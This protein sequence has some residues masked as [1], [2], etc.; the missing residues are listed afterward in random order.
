M[1]LLQAIF[2]VLLFAWITLITS[3]LTG[4]PGS[5]ASAEEK[6]EI[7][8]QMGHSDNVTSVSFSPDGRYMLSGSSDDTMKLWE[9]SSGREIRTFQGDSSSV[10][11][12]AFS[13][14]RQ[15]RAFGKRGYREALGSVERQ[16]NKNIQGAYRYGSLRGLQPG[17]QICAIRKR[18]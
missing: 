11:S 8:V 16:G 14:G 4:M 18:G 2:R 9:V 12:V 15:V 6:P 1:I 10:T 3:D 5:I 13:P 7:F 17:R